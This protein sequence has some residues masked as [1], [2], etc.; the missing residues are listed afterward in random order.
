MPKPYQFA[1]IPR[2][3]ELL[4]QGKTHV[5]IRVET[6]VPPR[7]ISRWLKDGWLRRPSFVPV[8]VAPT[9]T[10]E[11][12]PQQEWIAH[13]FLDLV[14][15]PA[16][17]ERILLLIER[18]SAEGF[19]RRPPPVPVEVA[20]TD[21]PE[22]SPEE[23][24]TSRTLLDLGMDPAV[25]MRILELVE[26]TAPVSN[27]RW[28][29]WLSGYVPLVAKIPDEWAA[30]VAFLPMLGRDLI[31]PALTDLAELMH[32]SVP[33]EDGRL[34][35]HYGSLAKPLLQNARVEL[36]NFLL[37]ISGLEMADV[38]PGSTVGPA[39]LPGAEA[40]I[41]FEVLLRCPHVDRP[42]RKRRLVDK[43]DRAMGLHL[44]RSMPMGALALTWSRRLDG[45][46]PWLETYANHREELQEAAA[47]E[48]GP[49]L[50]QVETLVLRRR[51]W[52]ERLGRRI[53]RRT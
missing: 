20:P 1:L 11:R 40:D 51:S 2:V 43:E 53:S 42:V 46:P 14:K 36:Q 18:A 50:M 15:D 31:N 39:T 45:D 12:E 21:D 34:R 16:T 25:V 33:W 38:P 52:L 8:E 22:P 41:A 30:A 23:E 28:R 49:R 26:R 5:Q 6:G 29:E 35:R 13:S 37:F 4:D 7:T 48:N 24:W 27:R 17:I 10:R 9:V 47:G 44:P 3:Q 32:E 19:L